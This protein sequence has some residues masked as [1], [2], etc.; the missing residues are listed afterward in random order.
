MIC[1]RFSAERRCLMPRRKMESEAGL[2]AVCGRIRSLRERLGM[3]QKVLAA[4]LGVTANAVSNWENG[5]S[6]P[7][8]NLLP[9]LFIPP[10]WFALVNVTGGFG[11]LL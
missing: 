9:A 4:R 3:E 7:D 8:L 2:P 5:R 10:I 11:G 1:G 6:R